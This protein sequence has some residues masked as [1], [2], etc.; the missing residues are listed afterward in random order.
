MHTC[1]KKKDKYINFKVKA[2]VF[3]N[4]AKICKRKNG[5]QKFIRNEIFLFKIFGKKKMK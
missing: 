5:K 3:D 2:I 4:E 1:A